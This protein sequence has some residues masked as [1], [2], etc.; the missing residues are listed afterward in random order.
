MNQTLLS[1]AY[2]GCPMIQGMLCSLRKSKSNCIWREQYKA[3]E[4][5][6]PVRQTLLNTEGGGDKKRGERERVYKI[7]L[8]KRGFISERC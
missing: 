8:S 4:L 2:P 6:T 3:T 1:I 7:T 5:L